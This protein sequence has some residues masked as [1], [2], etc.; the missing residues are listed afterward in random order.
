[1]RP[2]QA[3]MDGIVQRIYQAME[4]EEHL[5]STLFILCGDHGMNDVGNH[6]GSSAGETSAALVFMSPRFNE[7]NDINI[8][9]PIAPTG[10]F[11]YHDKIQQSDLVPT[12]ASLLGFPIPK[13]NLGLFISNFLSLWSS[14]YIVL[15]ICT[16][17]A[18]SI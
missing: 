2:K 18:E 17:C 11:E 7:M 6:G 12:L 15:Q 8:Q 9:S 16:I 13:N 14:M 4:R 3:E 5:K 10:E 1:M